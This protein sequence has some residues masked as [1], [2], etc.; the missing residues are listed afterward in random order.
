MSP[1]EPILPQNQAPPP[2]R[3][4]HA[5]GRIFAGATPR[6]ALGG[7]DYQS[8]CHC[9]KTQRCVLT[10]EARRRG[11]DVTALP[12]YQ[13]DMLPAG[14][15]YM[16]ALS[17]PKTVDVGKSKAK[18]EKQMASFGSGSRAIVHVSRGRNGHVFIAENMNGKVRYVDP[19]TN[20]RYTSVS[21]SNVSSV[22]VTRLD[23]Q[24]FTDYAKNAFTRKRV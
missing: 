11:Y 1:L 22:Q 13:G 18:L 23:N 9:S 20:R 21:F 3:L 24:Q 8:E 2:R 16:K 17:D 4:F 14:R 10:Y 7:F 12:T 6:A 19:Q 5:R 15:D